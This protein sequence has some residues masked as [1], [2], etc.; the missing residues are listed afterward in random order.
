MTNAPDQAGTASS[1]VQEMLSV[2]GCAIAVLLGGVHTAEI[3]PAFQR[4]QDW[5]SLCHEQQDIRT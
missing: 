5:V 4:R 3:F 2:S 1:L